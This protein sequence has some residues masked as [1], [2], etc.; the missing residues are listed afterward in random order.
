MS[1]ISFFFCVKSLFLVE[2]RLSNYDDN[3]KDPRLTIPYCIGTLSLETKLP[4]KRQTNHCHGYYHPPRTL[5]GCPY[6]ALFVTYSNR[7]IVYY[8]TCTSID[9]V[10]III[11][12]SRCRDFIVNEKTYIHQKLFLTASIYIKSD[13]NSKIPK[14]CA[15]PF[16]RERNHRP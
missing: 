11:Y 16:C 1:L 12:L 13:Q 3:E 15:V 7:P 10:V 4:L 14:I 5:N 8:G 6:S 2:G 9:L